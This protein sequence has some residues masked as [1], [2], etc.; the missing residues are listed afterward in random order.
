MQRNLLRTVVRILRKRA[1]LALVSLLLVFVAAAL[2]L[3][4]QDKSQFPDGLDAVQAAPASHKVL[5]ENTF[6]RV[7]EVTVPPGTKEPM[8]HHRWPSIFLS[9][10]PEGRTHHLRYFTADGNVRDLSATAPVSASSEWHIHWA[11]PEPLHALE[12]LDTPQDAAAFARLPSV[13]RV[14][15]K[16]AR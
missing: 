3:S 7:L 10:G 9:Y 1:F 5:F 15:L 4:S 12:N 2:A 16:M 11:E 13:I 14:E 8:H 6:V